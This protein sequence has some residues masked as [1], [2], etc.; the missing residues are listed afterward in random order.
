MIDVEDFSQGDLKCQILVVHCGD[1]DEEAHP[2]GFAL[3]GKLEAGAGKEN[4]KR[5]AEGAAEEAG[6][7]KKAKVAEESDSDECLIVG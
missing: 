4:E 5:P 2:E 1:L 6:P 7:S 3:A